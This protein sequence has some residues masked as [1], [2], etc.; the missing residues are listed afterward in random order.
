MKIKIFKNQRW[1]EIPPDE[2]PAFDWVDNSDGYPNGRREAFIVITKVLPY[3]FKAVG[4]NGYVVSF[5][6][7]SGDVIRRGLFWN[8]EDAEVFA[9]KIANL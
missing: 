2:N 1:N 8:L 3:E 6:P 5:V 9:N 7:K 4:E